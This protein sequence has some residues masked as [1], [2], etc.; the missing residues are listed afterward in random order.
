MS[1]QGK[2]CYWLACKYGN[3]WFLLF[4]ILVSSSQ[5]V[6]VLIT[7][8]HVKLQRASAPLPGDV[9]FIVNMSTSTCSVLTKNKISFTNVRISSAASLTKLYRIFW[10]LWHKKSEKF[11]PFPRSF[12]GWRKMH[13][14]KITSSMWSCFH[15]HQILKCCL[16]EKWSQ[17]TCLWRERGERYPGLIMSKYPRKRLTWKMEEFLFLFWVLGII[18]HT[19]AAGIGSCLHMHDFFCSLCLSNKC[20]LAAIGIR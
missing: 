9:C 18:V 17:K 16:A 8:L 20:N 7:I 10:S 2:K 6:K 1:F 14:N 5:G 19:R 3:V 4:G 13:N 12:R 11:F 15:I